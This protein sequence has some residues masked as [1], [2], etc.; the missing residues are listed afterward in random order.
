MQ[1]KVNVK[2]INKPPPVLCED[3]HGCDLQ[4][5]TYPCYGVPDRLLLK[6]G[7]QSDPVCG[8]KKDL[9]TRLCAYFIKNYII[10]AK[11]NDPA[12]ALI[13]IKMRLFFPRYPL[14]PRPKY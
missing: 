3:L 6:Q 9:Q 2:P 4:S 10:C 7:P 12:T 1:T 8:P 5:T 14:K 11:P 13:P